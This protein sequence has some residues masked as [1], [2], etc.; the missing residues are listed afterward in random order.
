M[1]ERYVVDENGERVAVLLDIEDYE[2]IVAQHHALAAEEQSLSEDEGEL[3]DPEEAERRITEFITSAE[4]LPGP[5]VEELA[6][7][8]AELMR[9]TWSDVETIMSGKPHN[10][11]LATQLFLGQRARGLQPENP[12]QWRLHAATSLLSG[13]VIRNVDKRG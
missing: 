4:E 5:P 12:E 2:R 8:V 13:M 9:A 6:D 7:S 10:K 3:L 11:L 1:N